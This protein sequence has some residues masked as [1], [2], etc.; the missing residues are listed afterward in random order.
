LQQQELKED[1]D[2]DRSI[3]E[4]DEISIFFLSCLAL[5]LGRLNAV[6]TKDLVGEYGS[7]LLHTLFSQVHVG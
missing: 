5:L 6:E 1:F 3:Q 7:M 2:S 4:G